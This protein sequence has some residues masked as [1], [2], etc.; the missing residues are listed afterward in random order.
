[1]STKQYKTSEAQRKASRKYDAEHP[2]QLARRQKKYFQ[3]HKE[4]WNA[5]R[6]HRNAVLKNF[7]V[8]PLLDCL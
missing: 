1:M 5:Y 8:L 6:R 7:K 2:E 3:T 4:E